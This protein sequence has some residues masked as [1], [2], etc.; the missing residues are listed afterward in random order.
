MI[1]INQMF[2][3]PRFTL[4]LGL[5]AA[6]TLAS[7]ASPDLANVEGLIIDSTNQFRKAV[8]RGRVAPEGKLSKAA[9]AFADYMAN[10]DKYGHEADG[11]KLSERV[12]AHDYA[13][14]LVSE[15]I[16]YQY[17]SADFG[18]T[19]LAN[20]YFERWKKSPGHR[21]NMLES[22][23]IDTAVAV[24]RSEKTGRYYAVQL[25]GRPRSAGCQRLN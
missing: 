11:R 2:S 18:T 17:S 6:A 7:G 4:L 12:V 1:Y 14:C 19:E 13:Y 20:R 25:F 15:N 5:M 8:G 9:Q 21:E 10:T 22:S 23:V 3:R 24:A 16:A